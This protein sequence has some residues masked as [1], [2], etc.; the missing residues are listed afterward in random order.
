MIFFRPIEF[1]MLCN[2][3]RRAI[4]SKDVSICKVPNQSSVRSFLLICM[5]ERNL[6]QLGRSLNGPKDRVWKK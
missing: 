4:G 3:F 6:L 1:S 5:P 2:S